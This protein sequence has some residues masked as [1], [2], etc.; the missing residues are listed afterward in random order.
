MRKTLL[1]FLFAFIFKISLAQNEPNCYVER[2]TTENGLPS[3][4][5][6]DLQWD[7]ETG[8][9]WMA[10]GVGI[11][12]FNGM[13]FKVFDKENIPQ[14][15][16]NRML[17]ALHDNAGNIHIADQLWNTYVIQKNTPVLWRT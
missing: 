11:V 2:F 4:V 17:F 1:L 15:A 8:F 13:D 10:T 6:S 5:I 3:N 14:M 12:R 9:L 7:D 16:M